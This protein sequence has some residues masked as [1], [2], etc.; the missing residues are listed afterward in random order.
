MNSLPRN[1]ATP[2][3]VI[4]CLIWKRWHPAIAFYNGS[5][6][7]RRIGSDLIQRT[8]AALRK[9][10]ALPAEVRV[11]VA[12][13]DQAG[14]NEAIERSWRDAIDALRI[15]HHASPI[16][17]HRERRLLIEVAGNR[18]FVA[19][20][21]LAC[22]DSRDIPPTWLA[23]LIAEGSPESAAIV[24]KARR[25]YETDPR[26]LRALD[27]FRGAA[28]RRV[29]G[30]RRVRQEPPTGR[31]NTAR[32]WEMLDQASSSGNA[33]VALRE[34]LEPLS[35]RQ[36]GAFD[37]LFGSM[38]RRA[39][40]RD[41]WGAAYLMLGGC[42][43]DAFK[44]FRAQLIG[45][46][47]AVFER[48]LKNP[49]LLANDLTDTQGDEALT[50]VAN[51]VYVEKVGRNLPTPKG[52]RREPVGRPWNFDSRDEARARYP[53]LYRRFGKRKASG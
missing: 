25:L 29:L 23:V 19:G 12:T 3:E 48:V 37:R 47:R 4:D 41:L 49:D 50:T 36:I 40:R 27:A 14:S 17:T 2:E 10:R 18:Q 22:K 33:D 42:S 35:P 5:K 21:R 8:V 44:D 32:F 20:M 34:L 1:P 7:C 9:R 26:W 28:S 45:R 11:L 39:Y 52:E 43:D 6:A 38:L 51:A 16:G 13:I 31:I 15:L 53:R 24:K 46:G 30:R